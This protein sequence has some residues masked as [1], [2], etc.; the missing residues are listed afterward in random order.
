MPFLLVVLRGVWQ[1]LGALESGAGED[2]LLEDP[3]F[4]PCLCCCVFFPLVGVECCAD[5]HSVNK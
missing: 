2:L 3:T 5:G 4:S 1:K